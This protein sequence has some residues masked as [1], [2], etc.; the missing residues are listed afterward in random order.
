MSLIVKTNAENYDKIIDFIKS[1]LSENIIYEILKDRIIFKILIE[2]FE[3][4]KTFLEILEKK[5]N[6]LNVKSYS[7]S[8][9]SLCDALLR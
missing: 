7:I 3:S 4:K 5:M 2:E 6:E 1:N 8:M 9:P